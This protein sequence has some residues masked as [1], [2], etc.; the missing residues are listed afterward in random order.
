MDGRELSHRVPRAGVR[1]N[2]LIDS[3]YLFRLLI[4]Y[5]VR[6]PGEVPDALR[7]DVSGA[8]TKLLH[9]GPADSMG[10]LFGWL[11]Q[12]IIDIGARVGELNRMSADNPNGERRV[13]FFVKG[14][15]AL[16]YYL[17]TPDRGENDWDT[18]VVINPSLAPREWYATFSAV[19]DLLLGLLRQ[20]NE[21]FTTLV[22]AHV[23]ELAAYLAAGGADPADA[24]DEETDEYELSDVESRPHRAAARPS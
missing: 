14:G 9:N 18:Q 17:F 19:H 5:E 22:E 15:R 24:D 23:E 16:N 7:I 2:H 3:F 6:V 21:E 12:K 1:M 13:V 10:W 20:Y 11:E 4:R 8:L